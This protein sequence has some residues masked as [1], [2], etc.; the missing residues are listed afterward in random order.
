MLQIVHIMPLHFSPKCRTMIKMSGMYQ[1]MHSDISHNLFGKQH[2][3]AIEHNMMLSTTTAPTG[4][5]LTNCTVFKWQINFTANCL[6]IYWQHLF[7][8]SNNKGF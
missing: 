7:G 6:Q 4:F 1:L 5:R 2:Q 8:I 3:S